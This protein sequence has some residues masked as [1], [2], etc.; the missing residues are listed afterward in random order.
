[1]RHTFNP[2]TSIFAGL[3]QT[4][5]QTMLTNAQQALVN[6]VSGSKGE[7]F[8]YTQGDGSKSVTYTRANLPQLT[9]TIR[10][11]QA[12]LGIIPT[13]RRAITPIF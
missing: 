4:T 5:L 11:L 13:P 3:D 2:A 10:E 7:V 9:M 6:L 8:T 12:C 1:M